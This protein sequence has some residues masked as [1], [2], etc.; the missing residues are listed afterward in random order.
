[1]AI[2]PLLGRKRRSLVVRPKR[3]RVVV[4][5]Y[6]N[7]TPNSSV[8]CLDELGPVSP[9]TFPPPPSWSPGGRRI[10]RR[11]WSI[12]GVRKKR[13]VYGALRVR[14]GQAL[15]L[16]GPSR[17]TKGYLRLLQAVEKANPTGDL[18]LT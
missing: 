12:A 9:R 8:I 13:W 16:S 14:D 2:R 4:E 7:P 10:S 17:N 6:T 18:Y 15:T 11:R 1:M 3:T 5:L